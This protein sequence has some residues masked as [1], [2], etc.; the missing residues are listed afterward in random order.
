MKKIDL[1]RSP[2]ERV[3]NLIIVD[4]SGSMSAIYEEALTGM[5]KTILNIR[6]E[7]L[8]HPNIRQY[9]NL[10]TFDSNFYKQHLRHCPAEHAE[11]LS[12]NQYLPGAATPLYDAI[13]MAVTSLERHTTSNDAVLVTV[14]TDGEEN[15]S[16]KYNA[17]SLK[18]IIDRLVEKGWLFTYI[19][20]NQDTVY[21]AGKIGINNSLSYTADKEGAE[22]MWKKENHARSEFYNR[23]R[24]KR[25][26]GKS[27]SEAMRE[28]NLPEGKFFHD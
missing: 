20:A 27:L 2:K 11:P 24:T 26:T 18:K 15:C 21:E 3:L 5:N 8:K 1:T 7:S 13:G 25:A 16:T 4:E 14:I 22:A 17:E 28:E 10:I 23:I 19:G 6:D 9:V 12:P